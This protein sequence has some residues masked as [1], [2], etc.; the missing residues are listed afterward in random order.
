MELGLIIAVLLNPR[1]GLYR[2]MQDM[3]GKLNHALTLGNFTGAKFGLKMMKE[4]Q[5]KNLAKTWIDIHDKPMSFNARRYHKIE[6]HEG[7]MWA[8]AAYTRRSF[9]RCSDEVCSQLKELEFPCE[10]QFE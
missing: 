2:D 5:S 9:R 8:L 3:V 4:L 7:H 6:P 10:A 1:I